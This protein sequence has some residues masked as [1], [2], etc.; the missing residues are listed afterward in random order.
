MEIPVNTE[1]RIRLAAQHVFQKK[2]LSGARMQDIADEAGINKAM[3]HYYFRS[4]EKLFDLVFLESFQKIFPKINSILTSEDNLFQKIEHFVFEYI[5]VINQNPHLPLFVV[6][7]LAKNPEL[8]LQKLFSTNE[9][10]PKV[11]KLIKQIEEEIN[12]GTILPIKPVN[13]FL[14]I[15]SLCVFPYVGKP[16]VQIILNMD[17][18]Q[19][20]GLL[21]QRKQEVLGFVLNAIKA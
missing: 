12:K 4:K 8:F 14:N 15:I 21:E 18:E 1:E 2:G 17:D 3:L 5:T 16:L 11:D 19:Y 9:G 10:A 6:N 20:K 13:L 7:E